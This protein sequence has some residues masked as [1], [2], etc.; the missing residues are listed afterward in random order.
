M[1]QREQIERLRLKGALPKIDVLVSG[2]DA[3]G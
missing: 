2:D 1:L 3:L